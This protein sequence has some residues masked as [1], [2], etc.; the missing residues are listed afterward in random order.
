MV[1]KPPTYGMFAEP[2]AVHDIVANTPQ[3]ENPGKTV[4]LVDEGGL[5]PPPPPRRSRQRAGRFASPPDSR[6]WRPTSRWSGSATRSPN[7]P[8]WT[9]PRKSRAGAARPMPDP[10]GKSQLPS[11]RA[12]RTAVVWRR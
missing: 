2:L 9:R 3:P 10:P 8:C 4:R 7:G 11:A 6:R 12:R 5:S 1:N